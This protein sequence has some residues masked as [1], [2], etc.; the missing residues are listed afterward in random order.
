MA[1]G[2]EVE[3][4]EIVAL[5]ERDASEI[6]RVAAKMLSEIVQDAAC[7]ADGGGAVLQTEAVEC[8]DFEMVADGE[9]SGFRSEYPIV[10]AIDDPAEARFGRPLTPN[11]L[12]IRWGEGEILFDRIRVGIVCRINQSVAEQITKRNGF[13]WKDNF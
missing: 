10:V 7:C 12:P 13:A 5:V 1:Q 3:R 4:E 2:G 6:R 8:G 9:E 11:P